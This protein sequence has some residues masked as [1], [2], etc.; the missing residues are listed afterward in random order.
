MKIVVFAKKRTTK[1]GKPFT[2]F[3]TRMTNKAGEEITA[4]VRFREECGQPKDNECPC[5]IEFDKGDANMT[6]KN[7]EITDAETGEIKDAQSRTLWITKWK[8]SP[9]KYVDH[10][11]DDFE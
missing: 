5:Y 2:A 3:V 10:S 8:K 6:V 11:L 1:E 9:E 7:L 4:G